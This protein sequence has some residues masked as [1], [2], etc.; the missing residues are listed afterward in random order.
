MTMVELLVAMLLA[1]ILGAAVV[2]AFATNSH[3]FNQD[4]NIMRMQD[5]AR[6]A[7]RE[8]SFAVSMAGHYG[9]LLIPTS[10]TT[11]DNLTIGTDCGAAGIVE[12]VYRLVQPATGDSLSIT[13]VDNAT[14]AQANGNHSCIQAS[15]FEAGTDVISI[16]RVT[17]ARAAATHWS[18]RDGPMPSSD[19]GA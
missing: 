11:D 15:E 17:G 1:V 12:W 16:K 8:L 9:E 2:S 7:L 19:A 3:S 5:D 10:V 14:A 6:H 18:C 13:G 4:E